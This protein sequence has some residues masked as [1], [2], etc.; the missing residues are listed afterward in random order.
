MKPRWR[1][2]ELTR[3]GHLYDLAA[4]SSDDDLLAVVASP[5]T[6]DWPHDLL[7]L[8]LDTEQ[9]DIKDTNICLARYR[10]LVGPQETNASRI[11]WSSTTATASGQACHLLFWRTT[12]DSDLTQCRMILDPASRPRF[13]PLGSLREYPPVHGCS[14]RVP[15]AAALLLGAH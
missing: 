13:A 3:L 1:L 9:H 11:N 10:R 15:L 14:L 2:P 7:D 6:V 8:R 5:A 4:S 12:D